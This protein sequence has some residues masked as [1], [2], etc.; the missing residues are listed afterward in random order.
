M[1]NSINPIQGLNVIVAVGSTDGMA[2]AASCLR[3]SKNSNIQLVFTQAHQVDKVD[4]S[5]WPENSKVGFIDLGVN[6]EGLTPNVQLTIDFV[7]KIYNSGHTILF[8]AD[9]HDKKAWNEVLQ[10]CGHSKDD[11]TIKPKNRDK[12]TSSCAILAKAFGE[13][14]DVHT[15]EL[16]HAGDQ[17]DRMNFNTRFG[18]IFNSS[19]KSNMMDPQRRP[20]LV[21]HLAESEIPDEKIQGWINEY[22]EIQENQPRILET[23]QDLGNGIAIYDASIGR[24]DATAIFNEAYKTSPIVVLKNTN[25]FH[26]GKMQSG[27]SIAT[28]R[29]DLNVLEIVKKAEINASGMPLKANFAIKDLD[30]AIE[31]VKNSI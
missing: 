26:E 24:H 4:V 31:A 28:N 15:K 16:L 19:I 8:I 17:A 27:A 10:K 22:K 1:A 7:N 11:L 14:A 2:G 12:Y 18:E 25:V 21:K 23:F 9:E 13:S 6:N 30:A 20:H 5:K 3:Q 29:K